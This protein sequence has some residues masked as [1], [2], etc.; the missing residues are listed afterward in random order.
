[1]RSK[2]WGARRSCPPRSPRARLCFQHLPLWTAAHGR[3][4]G[5]PEQG[6]AW[7]AVGWPKA[8]TLLIAH[9]S[10]RVLFSPQDSASS[11]WS[12]T[13]GVSPALLPKE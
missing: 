4:C 2:E 1:M 11:P 6:A 5:K 9:R 3:P 13:S 10:L 12:C 7:A 8:L